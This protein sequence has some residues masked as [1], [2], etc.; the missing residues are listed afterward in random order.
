MVFTSH[1]VTRMS[2]TING[3]LILDLDVVRVH[4]LVSVVCPSPY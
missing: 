4:R 2:F 1:E 3:A